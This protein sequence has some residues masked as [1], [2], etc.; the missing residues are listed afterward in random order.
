MYTIILALTAV[1]NFGSNPGNLAMYK[2]VPTATP[3][4]APLVVV[5]HGCSQQASGMTATGFEQLAEERKFYLVLPQTNSDNNPVNCFNWG[6]EYGDPA[7]L[8]RGQGENESI[9]QMVDKMKADHSIDASKVFVAGFSS[10]GAMAIVMLATWPDV[11]AAGASFSGVSYRCATTVQQ[12]YDC[13]ALNAHPERKKD[14]AAWGDLVRAAGGGVSAAWPR[15]ILWH[16]T[17]DYTVHNDNQIELIEQWTNVHGTDQTAEAVDTVAGHERSRHVAGGVTVV[18]SWRIGGMNHAVPIGPSDPE[19]ACGTTGAFV[20]NKGVCAAYHTLKFF[21]IYESDP[22]PGGGDGGTGGGSDGGG[23]VPGAPSVEITSP[24]DGSDVSGTVT[25][26]VDASDEGG[27]RRVEF[28]IDDVLKGSD[29]SA[30]YEYRW[31]TANYEDGAHT[32]TAKAYDDLDTEGVDE[33]TVNVGASSGAAGDGRVDPIQF[34]CHITPAR[35]AAPSLAAALAAL[36]LIMLA[37]RRPRS[38][39][40]PSRRG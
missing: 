9:K 31:P 20:E 5:L 2:Y 13:M 15:V 7:N 18:E 21:G 16:G 14:P 22:P 28:W 33:V 37:R 24:A 32:I 30:P 38:V 39:G 40:R 12:A 35:R 36:A 4:N 25:I 26:A 6:G 17:S 29:G 34:G 3:A 23:G 1:A 11:F 19:H 27:I 10:G 8:I